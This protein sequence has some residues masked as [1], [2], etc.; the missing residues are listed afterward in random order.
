MDGSGG[1]LTRAGDSWSTRAKI[2][3]GLE[4]VSCPSAS[5]CAA[6]GSDDAVLY[7]LPLSNA[8]PPSISG[9]T[10]LGST[11]T[12]AHGTWLNEPTKLSYQW[13]RCNDS[14]DSCIAIDGATGQTHPLATADAGKTIRVEETATNPAG[15]ARAVS[16]ATGEVRVRQGKAKVGHLKVRGVT[17]DV[18]L[19]CA[20]PDGI[21]CIVDLRIR[22]TG[23]PKREPTKFQSARRADGGPATIVANKTVQLAPGGHRTVRMRL[24]AAGKRRLATHGKLPA[25]LQV[26]QVTGS[27]SAVIFNR[28]VTFGTRHKR[29]R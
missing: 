9:D 26:T 2:A 8:S 7:S 27:G 21:A 20:S 23:A 16:A 18:P 19:K 5:F 14:G 24:N 12:E 1:A 28:R 10:T 3:P 6:V 29:G 25:E 13:L 17:V 11:L 15:T 22:T 4:S